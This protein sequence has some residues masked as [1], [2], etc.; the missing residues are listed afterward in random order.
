MRTLGRHQRKNDHI[1]TAP[2]RADADAQPGQ[3]SANHKNVGI[4]DFHKVSVSKV[5][6]KFEYRNRNKLKKDKLKKDK[7]RIDLKVFPSRLFGT[8]SNFGFR[9]S[10]FAPLAL[11]RRLQRCH[12]RRNIAFSEPIAALVAELHVRR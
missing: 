3:T 8:V 9:A 2:F 1:V 11:S 5:N 12:V 6:S 4:N 10:N 7:T